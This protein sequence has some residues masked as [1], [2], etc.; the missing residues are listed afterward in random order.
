MSDLVQI[1][2]K[3][4]QCGGLGAILDP[5]PHPQKPITGSPCRCSTLIHEL[6]YLGLEI[7]SAERIP[8]SSSPLAKHRHAWIRGSWTKT[9]PH[10]RAVLLALRRK[11]PSLLHCTLTDERIRQSMFA[12]GGATQLVTGPDLVIVRLGFVGQKNDSAPAALMTALMDRVDFQRRATWV[13][14]DPCYPFKKS[15]HSWSSE[16]EEWRQRLPEVT[17]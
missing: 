15:H 1:R 12:P 11:K 14:D 7:G 9:L 13:V 3:C 4:A 17:L 16:L 2:L 8:L 5:Q 10:L 6:A